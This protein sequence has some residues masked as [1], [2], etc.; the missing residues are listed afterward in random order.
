MKRGRIIG[1]VALVLLLL[2]A[3]TSSAIFF[4][5]K[6]IPLRMAFWPFNFIPEGDIH[7]AGI[8]DTAIS[9]CILVTSTIMVVLILI[10]LF[11]NH[12]ERKFPKK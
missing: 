12:I 7:L 3:F 9:S 6:N 2:S 10:T 4:V 11:T 8:P 1:E 5:Q